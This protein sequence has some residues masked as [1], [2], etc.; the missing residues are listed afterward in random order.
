MSLYD[1]WGA[2]HIAPRLMQVRVQVPTKLAISIKLVPTKLAVAVN[3]LAEGDED[4]ELK[5]GDVFPKA[6]PAEAASEAPAA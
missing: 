6:A 2:C 1:E 4:K 5:V 3:Q